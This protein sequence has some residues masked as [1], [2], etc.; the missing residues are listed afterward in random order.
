[1]KQVQK[2]F[3]LIELIVVIVILGILAAV[4]LPKFSDLSAQARISKMQA[5]QGS[6]KAA[7]VMAHGQWLATGG[8][9]AGGV[10]SVEGGTTI[11]LSNGYP[12]ATATG[13]GAAVDFSDYNIVA[14]GTT[15][16]SDSN[17]TACILTYAAAANTTTMP[18]VSV[19]G[20]TAATC[21]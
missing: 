16:S 7:A 21:A 8:A 10:A 13:I 14:T 17:H 12:D 6:I 20:A 1:M 3:T 4:A 19:A 9:S 18:V 2:G 11:A 15:Y 5:L